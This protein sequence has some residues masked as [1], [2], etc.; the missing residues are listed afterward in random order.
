MAKTTM[1]DG[2]GARSGSRTTG[3][4]LPHPRQDDATQSP[5]CSAYVPLSP[6]TVQRM[7]KTTTDEDSHSH[8][9]RSTSLSSKAPQNCPARSSETLHNSALAPILSDPKQ[10]QQHRTV[11]TEYEA[12]HVGPREDP[13]AVSEPD[14]QAASRRCRDCLSR[15]A[16]WVET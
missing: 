2:S 8:P 14:R 6:A 5:S 10:Q 9:E 7:Q 4:P 11:Q 1:M 16:A 12:A 3:R 15:T 13:K